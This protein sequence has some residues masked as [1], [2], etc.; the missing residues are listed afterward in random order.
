[1]FV[2]TMCA[3]GAAAGVL[4]GLFGIGGGILVIPGLVYLA[5]MDQKM[6]QGTTLLMLLPPIGLFA[7]WEY[8]R[9]GEAS[10]AAAL[11]LC[12][13][14]LLGAWLGARWSGTFSAAWLRR[15]FG[16]LMVLVGL[17]MLLKP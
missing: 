9:R 5:G 1:M 17:R 12:I 3:L 14:F 15:G 13:G 4:G 7:A 6:A 2:L 16:I 8:W 11:W 10:W